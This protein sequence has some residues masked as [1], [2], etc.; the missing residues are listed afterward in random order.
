MNDPVTLDEIVEIMANADIGVI[1]KRNDDF[2]GEAFSTKTLEFMSMGV[3]IIVAR[4]KIDQYY[5]ND[6]IVKFFEAGNED[7]LAK[8]MLEMIHNE[9]KREAF[10]RNASKFIEEFSWKMRK[11]CYLDLVHC[12][13]QVR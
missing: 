5:F 1:P 6:S 8:A 10:S 2:G 9:E 7:D 4:T 3:P 11:Q 12:L 13:T